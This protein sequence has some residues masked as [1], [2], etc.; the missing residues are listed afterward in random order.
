MEK[1]QGDKLKLSLVA[2]LCV[3]SQFSGSLMFMQGIGEGWGNRE[4]NR[5]KLFWLSCR[6]NKESLAIFTVVDVDGKQALFHWSEIGFL[7]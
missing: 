3:V 4:Y 7:K 1:S 2:V 6:S 5:E